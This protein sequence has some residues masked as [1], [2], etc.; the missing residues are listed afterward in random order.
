MSSLLKSSRPLF[1]PSLISSKFFD[2]EH[3]WAI[4]FYKFE[5]VKEEILLRTLSTSILLFW[6][7]SRFLSLYIFCTLPMNQPLTLDEPLGQISTMVN[8]SKLPWINFKKS[9]MKFSTSE[10]SLWLRLSF[11]SCLS[12][13]KDYFLARA[14][15]SLLALP[16][17]HL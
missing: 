6:E 17:S 13:I 9:L 7:I 14:K 8:D 15:T 1:S 10:R 16:K 12:S 5:L 2:N 4:R 3:F 11:L